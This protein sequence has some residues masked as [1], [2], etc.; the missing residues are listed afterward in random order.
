[1]SRAMGNLSFEGQGGGWKE[2]LVAG[3][4]F[5]PTRSSHAMLNSAI[6]VIPGAP[7]GADPE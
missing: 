4:P 3:Y 1:L 6:R 5:R 2:A 7:F